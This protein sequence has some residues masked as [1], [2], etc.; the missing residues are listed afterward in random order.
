MKMTNYPTSHLEQIEV[1]EQCFYCCSTF[2][3][4]FN[5]ENNSYPYMNVKRPLSAIKWDSLL[6]PIYQLYGEIHPNTMMH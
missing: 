3:S 6:L 2:C 1:K 4:H 5:N